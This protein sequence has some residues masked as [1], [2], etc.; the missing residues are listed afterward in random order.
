MERIM[1]PYKNFQVNSLEFTYPSSGEPLFSNLSFTL[2]QGWTGLVGPN[3][4]GKTTLLS[5]LGGLLIP[6]GGSLG[7]PGG[8]SHSLFLCPQ[9]VHQPGSDIEEMVYAAFEGDKEAILYSSRF[10]LS[11][12]VFFRWETLSPGERKRFQLA[13]AL[14]K[15][16]QFLAVDEPT[17]HID[18]EGVALLQKGLGNFEGIGLIVSHDRD[19]LDNLCSQ[20]LFLEKSGSSLRP[21]G[22]SSAMAEKKREALQAERAF[23]KARGE[24]RSLKREAN[25]RR[26]EA[27]RSDSRVSKKNLHRK[28]SDGRA[29]INRARVTGKDGVGGKLLRQ[30]EGRLSQAQ[31]RLDSAQ[32]ISAGKQG[33]SIQTEASRRDSLL[34]LPSGSLPM[35]SAL[36]QFPELIIRPHHRIALTGTNGSGK[37]TL[38]KLIS[39]KISLD[40]D[41]LFYLSQEVDPLGRRGVKESLNLLDHEELGRV[42]STFSRLGSD[43]DAILTSQNP[44]PGETRKLI[45][46][47]ALERAPAL[48][49][50][51]EPTNHMDLPSRQALEEALADINSALI[52]VSHDRSFRRRLCDLNWHID[53]HGDKSELKISN[54]MA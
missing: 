48:I 36:L 12:E 29:K 7:F 1:P 45:I 16:P 32:H 53:R 39:E 5:L 47:L 25:R 24:M 51:D 18:E 54:G 43:P 50:L 44:S 40:P 37:T 30:M 8:S 38:L 20:T 6:T 33:I 27:D 9:D 52:I 34:S 28:D 49:I 13:A 10:D 14:W 35:G 17:N 3:G 42:L 21:G 2:A 46:S 31:N 4:I 41:Q 26:V 15:E 19:L 23:M 11:L 22:V